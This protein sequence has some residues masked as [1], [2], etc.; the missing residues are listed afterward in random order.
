MVVHDLACGTGSMLRWLSPQLPGPQ[1]WVLHDVDGDLLD[2]AVMSAQRLPNPAVL[3]VEARRGDV[4]RLSLGELADADLVTAS[5]LLDLLTQEEVERLAASCLEPGCPVLLTLTVTGGARLDPPHPLDR[6]L[7]G[8]FDRHQRRLRGGRSRLGP[9][10]ARIAARTFTLLGAAVEVRPAPWRLGAADA[11]L[12]LSWLD[13][14]L[15]AACTQEPQLAA[16]VAGYAR[17]RKRDADAGRLAVAVQHE[18][19]LVLRQG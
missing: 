1:R 3:A 13:G 17:A 8:A 6:V 15:S 19:L 14:W 18:D 16:E 2:V 11:D 7:A 5:A 4:T 12:I 9:D 10:A